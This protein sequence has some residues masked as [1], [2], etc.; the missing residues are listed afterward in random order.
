[1][2][3]RRDYFLPQDLVADILP[4][5]PTAAAG[6][7]LRCVSKSWR[8]LLSDPKFIHRQLYLD[9]DK[10]RAVM[11]T[12]LDLR[13]V[14][15]LRYSSLSDD[16]LLPKTTPYHDHEG[17]RYLDVPAAEVHTGGDPP[18]WRYQQIVGCCNGLF[19][20]ADISRSP[21]TSSRTTDLILWNPSTSE[22]KLLPNSHYN[23]ASKVI[24]SLGFGFDSRTGNYKVLRKLENDDTH[25]SSSIEIYSLR[26]GSWK[27][28]VGT[29]K[30][31]L[32]KFDLYRARTAWMHHRSSGEKT[33]WYDFYGNNIFC[34]DFREER[35]SHQVFP[36][37]LADV[38]KGGSTKLQLAATSKED[39]LM[40]VF[41]H[42]E[43]DNFE[44]W[45]LLRFQSVES[46]TK[47]FC[48]NGS[49]IFGSIAERGCGIGVSGSGQHIVVKENSELIKVDF[50]KERIC[51]KNIIPSLSLE[52][53]DRY[54][55]TAYSYVPSQV[56]IV[57][58]LDRC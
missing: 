10:D 58:L 6:V 13:D 9:D 57:E 17:L 48:C 18:L 37:S 35:F 54:I 36:A 4:R 21:Q 12:R 29:P 45:G 55:L 15:R 25:D 43:D 14:S 30:D 5:L 51:D 11:I 53:I 32:A 22:T 33:Y 44:I 7:Q 47:L 24:P 20:I 1:M 46:W 26:N 39:S 23:V 50:Q 41:R 16:T 52:H 19:C 3:Q 34:F 56:S 40:A 42:N 49:R 27:G 8:R 28:A 38:A 31:H 2:D